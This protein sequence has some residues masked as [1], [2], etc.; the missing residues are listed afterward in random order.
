MQQQLED[1]AAAMAERLASL[2]NQ[3]AQEK[4]LREQGKSGVGGTRWR[5]GRSDRSL[6]NYAREVRQKNERRVE[7]ARR[8][9]PHKWD[10]PPTTAWLQSSSDGM[11]GRAE[12]PSLVGKL[13]PTL[14]LLPVMSA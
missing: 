11:C 7:A 6:S 1:D 14:T 3:M 5:S 4:E 13:Q 10:D 9:N 12:P 2:R 8:G